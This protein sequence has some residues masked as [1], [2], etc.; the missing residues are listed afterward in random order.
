MQEQESKTKNTFRYTVTV[1]N[2][3]AHIRLEV[4]GGTYTAEQNALG[5]YTLTEEAN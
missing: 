4:H 2:G 1:E 3:A 5:A